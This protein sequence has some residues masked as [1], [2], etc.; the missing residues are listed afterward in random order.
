MRNTRVLYTENDP[1][2]RRVLGEMLSKSAE[3]EV[4]GSFSNTNDTLNRNL[5]SHADVA[6]IDFALDQRDG[7]I[8]RHGATQLREAKIILR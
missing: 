8:G 5:V 1:A 2:L 4:I 3:L 7:R 6:L